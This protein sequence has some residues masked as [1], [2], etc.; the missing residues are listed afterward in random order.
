M[1]LAGARVRVKENYI[2]EILENELNILLFIWYIDINDVEEVP[3][4]LEIS[5]TFYNHSRG[6][7]PT[8]R[9]IL[10]LYQRNPQRSYSRAPLAF[11]FPEGG[12]EGPR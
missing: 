12:G 8:N 10:F 6:A 2:K 4:A 9:P 3:L 5:Q 11:L 7:S 1:S